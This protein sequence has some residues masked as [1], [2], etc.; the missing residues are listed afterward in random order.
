MGSNSSNK[1]MGKLR[2]DF[3]I[4]NRK[5]NGKPLVYLDS[6][7][8]SQKPL[9]VINAVKDYYESHNANVHRSIYKLGEEATEIYETAHKKVAEFINAD[10][11]EVIFT[12]NATES[13]NL[14]MYS[15]GMHNI[16]KG[17]E[18]VLTQMEHHSNL[19]PWQF[20]AK[21]KGAVLKF[22]EID[23]K[24]G[25]I[26]PE[27]INKKITK[28]TKLVSAIHM[29][30]VLGTINPVEEIIE[31]AHKN[32]SLVMIDAAQSVPHMPIDVKKL[33]A[34][35]LVFS[36][37]KMLG[38]TGIGV[39]YTKKS[40]LEKMNP[41]IY[42]GDMISSVSY[43]DAK[44]NELPWKFEAG[45]PNVAGAA[46]L[47]AAID[48]LRKIGL[49]KIQKHENSLAEYALKQLLKIPQLTIYGPKEIPVK[50]RGA[51]ISFT[52]G[53]IHPH[54]LSTLLDR[55]GIAIRGG[56]HCAMPLAKLLGV[57]ATSRASFY[58]YN[59]KE[60]I[61]SLVR[62]LENAARIFRL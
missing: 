53:D 22:M 40:I 58:F 43:E 49:G 33:D 4:L 45:T 28:K 27:E 39:L 32:N 25:R 3:P 35:F 19:V 54:D 31:K 6:A 46:G 41:F 21:Q 23:T 12:K 2:K 5:I 14:V 50:N 44:W 62:S 20:L 30:N 24:I 59:T 15:W 37:H 48:Y 1:E 56:H 61:D 38:P 13:I 52:L 11:E 55:D 60:E 10:F 17:D 36:A 42:G 8:T 34:D 57:T 18:I 51:V 16:K 9:Q 29:S 26:K 47:S 7:A